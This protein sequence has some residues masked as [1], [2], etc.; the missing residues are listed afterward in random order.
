MF[1]SLITTATMMLMA[2]GGTTTPRPRPPA[3]SSGS[4][5]S[6]GTTRLAR[7]QAAY[8][9]FVENDLIIEE[10]NLYNGH[11]FRLGHNDFSGS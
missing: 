3:G 7:E 10:S 4:T 8:E 6:G 9:T 2:L 11:R 5:R 1:R